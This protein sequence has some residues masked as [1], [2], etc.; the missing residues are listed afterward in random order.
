MTM[1]IRHPAT[2]RARVA[3]MA[4]L[5]AGM[6]IW[7]PQAF[8]RS[9]EIADLVE[10]VS[11]AV[12]TVLAT[13]NAQPAAQMPG[14][15]PFPPGSPFGEFFR[16]FGI[17]EGRMAPDGGAPRQALGSGFMLE[18]DGY[19]ITN[20]HVVDEAGAVKIRLGDEREFT[21]TVIGTDEQTDLALLKI[22]A[23]DLPHLT[24]GDSDK[25]RVGE[26]VIAVG[27][28][29]GLGGTV[30]RG[31]VSA[32]ARDINS[33]PYVD[34]IQTD[35]AINR[36]NSG[37]PLFNMDGEVIGVNSAI[38]SPSGGSVGVGFA[39]PSNVVKTIVAQL[40]EHGS[41]ERGWLG[42]TIQNV[43]P[44]IAA[45]IGMKDPHGALV[46]DVA[47]DGP[48]NG[49]LK[50]G[51]VIASFGGK[52]VA[53]SRELP[54]L[55]AAARA[56][57]EVSMEVLRGGGERT[58]SVKIGH[59]DARRMA[60]AGGSQDGGSASGKLG[61]TLATAT[62]DTLQSLGL[63]PDLRGAVVTSLKGDGAAAAAG[64]RVGDVILRVGDKAVNSP[65]DV[66]KGVEDAKADAVLMQIARQG[67][68]IFV[69]VPLA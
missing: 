22:D 25:V 24:L 69:G 64:L 41:V 51:D 46:A 39:I 27:N 40:R 4:G 59:L 16:H 52:R 21:A 65:A 58:L 32:T 54:K 35:A 1:H 19:V 61:A 30:T 62:P 33:G 17:P 11:P 9:N 55:V 48:S 28:P 49:V 7:T 44:E 3:A 53:D 15:M 20:N 47:E 5:A 56:G 36:G 26:D 68:R 2:R 6:L 38:Y 37:G 31:I 13:R 67:A 10:R 23:S 8:A 29:F 60:A 45:A 18:S 42:V 43:T 50:T 57:D 14:G 34:F 12:V 63:D 66:R